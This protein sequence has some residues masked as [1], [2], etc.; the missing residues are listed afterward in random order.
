MYWEDSGIWRRDGEETWH[1]AGP[2]S[3][4]GMGSL[5]FNFL[6]NFAKWSSFLFGIFG[7]IEPKV[8]LEYGRRSQDHNHTD[9]QDSFLWDDGWDDPHSLWEFDHERFPARFDEA[10]GAPQSY[11]ACE[12][13][14]S[15]RRCDMKLGNISMGHMVTIQ[16]YPLDLGYLHNS[17]THLFNL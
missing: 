4:L 1:Q 17:W 3:A 8:M 12:T 5:F 15:S 9:L 14:P 10:R 7:I 2:N 16:F 6:G 13:P 11:L